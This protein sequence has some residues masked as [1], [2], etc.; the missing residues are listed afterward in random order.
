[1]KPKRNTTSQEQ[2]VATQGTL[3]VC[4]TPIGNL[5]DVSPHLVE[6][7]SRVGTI[8]AEA[9]QPARRLL[10]ALQ[11][12]CPEL[13]HFR[14]DC[15]ESAT[16]TILQRLETGTS[17][18]LLS[19]AGTPGVCD[20]AWQIVAACRQRKIPIVSV[21]GPSALSTALAVSGVPVQSFEFLGFLPHK[22]KSRLSC[23]EAAFERNRPIV[24]F[25]SPHRLCDT[26]NDLGKLCGTERQVVVL[27]ELTKMHEEHLQCT[28]G[29]LVELLA[30]QPPRGEYVVVL[31]ALEQET[32]PFDEEKLSTQIGDLLSGGM[33]KKAAIAFVTRWLSAPKNLAYRLVETASSGSEA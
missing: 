10:S 11:V 21:S 32:K 28:V 20:P 12:R 26:A 27:R 3:F 31:P 16:R 4:A 18:A 6:T 14:E 23:L 24:F 9:T 5:K 22:S 7:L 30:E 8:A 2:T 29:Q 17:V 25:E 13:I 19:E 1:M 33:N 15:A